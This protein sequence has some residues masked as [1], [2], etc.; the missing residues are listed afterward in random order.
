MIKV[1]IGN[2]FDSQAQTL[3]N[4]LNCV[5][6]MGK[7]VALECKKRFPDMYKDYLLRCAR[8]EVQLGRPYLYQRTV[9]PWILNFPTKHHWRQV[10]NL[11]AIEQ[12]LEYLRQHIRQWGITS[13]AV[14]PLGCGEG[15]LEWRIVGPTLYR[16]L[17]TL[18]I[19]V[20]LYAPYGTPHEELQASFLGASGR[21]GD[22]PVTMPEPR[23]IRPAWVAL[24]EI[25]QRIEAQPYHWPVGRTTFQKIAFVATQ[26]GLQTGLHFTKGSYGPFSP[27][28]KRMIGCLQNHGLIQEEHVGKMIQV[29]VGPTYADARTAYATALQECEPL[30]AG[31][32]DLFMRLDSRRAEVVATV[33]FAARELRERRA[34]RPSEMD[35]FTAVNEWKQKR[36]P[37]LREAE[38]ALA[39]RHL[40][41]LGWLDVAPSTALPVPEGD[42]AA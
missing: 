29:R 9:L 25:L 3:V 42:L 38:V 34:A 41:A 26:E 10:A 33:L 22:L 17:A 31:V 6:V 11:K 4:T 20:E 5:G 39:I 16:H 30:I 18:A 35:V 2:L 32:T 37:P 23:W 14:P 1:L 28:M 21:P 13:L 8:G 19:P 15:Q 12:G 24:V 36:R 27:E 40:A 7:G